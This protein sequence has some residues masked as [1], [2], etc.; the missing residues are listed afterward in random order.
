MANSNSFLSPYEIL[1]TA[2]ENKYLRK[3]YNFIM[4]LYVVIV[5]CV[6]SL[7]SPHRGD[8]N[9][10][11]QHTITVYKIEK[12]SLNYRHLLPD[13]ASWLTLS[14]SNYPHI[15][16]KFPWSQRCSIYWSSTVLN[17]KLVKWPH[18]MWL[19][20]FDVCKSV[21]GRRLFIFWSKSTLF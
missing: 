5:C 4:K 14:G 21:G 3:C 13:L 6:Y 18:A 7:E 9:E 11:S 15:S 17:L 8:S 20:Y 19:Y 2:Q 10:Y 16:N 12:H 1:P